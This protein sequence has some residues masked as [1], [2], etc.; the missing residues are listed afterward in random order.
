MQQRL[1][2][3]SALS[4]ASFRRWSWALWFLVQSARFARWDSNASFKEVTTWLLAFRCLKIFVSLSLMVVLVWL[5]RCYWYLGVHCKLWQQEMVYLFVVI[6]TIATLNFL[7]SPM[8]ALSPS[9]REDEI[10][11][12]VRVA[13]Q[14]RDYRF[15]LW[16]LLQQVLLV[17]FRPVLSDL[18]S[19][20]LHL[21]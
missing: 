10:F 17:H 12:S 20:R 14:G 2:V 1:L 5:Q 9:V 21:Y 6:T 13:P 8:D 19:Q 16:S 18:L 11:K 15:C 7:R 4:V 3:P